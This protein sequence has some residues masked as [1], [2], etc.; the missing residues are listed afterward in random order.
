MDRR[1]RYVAA[2]LAPPL[3]AGTLLALAVFI[4]G[5]VTEQTGPLDATT[6]ASFL[7]YA[8]SGFSVSLLVSLVVVLPLFL[9]LRRLGWLRRGLVLSVGGVIGT[10]LTFLAFEGHLV[11]IPMG[12]TIGVACAALFW[13]VLP[14]DDRRG[15]PRSPS[16]MRNPA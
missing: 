11:G 1:G 4:L 2:M 9:V 12:G 3:L 5:A 13:S 16:R 10:A 8:E 7:L 15:T 14:P 6:I